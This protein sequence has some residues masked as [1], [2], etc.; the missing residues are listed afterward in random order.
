MDNNLIGAGTINASSSSGSF[1]PENAFDGNES[2]FWASNWVPGSDPVRKAQLYYHFI[3][4]VWVKKLRILPCSENTCR[5]ITIS[6]S[7]DDISYSVIQ[8]LNVGTNTWKEFV[9]N[10][11]IQLV[12]LKFDCSVDTFNQ[13]EIREIQ[14]LGQ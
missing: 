1:P 7:V 2:T 6:Y 3:H 12:H 13:I 9:L 4:P 14:V 10:K 8:T 11:P 5:T